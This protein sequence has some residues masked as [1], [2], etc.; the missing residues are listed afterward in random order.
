MTEQ[1]NMEMFC[2]FS[3]LNL[4]LSTEVRWIQA[5]LLRLHSNI[6]ITSFQ[7]SIEESVFAPSPTAFVS[8]SQRNDPI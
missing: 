5:L 4:H 7:P 3:H 8:V 2:K 1:K 6:C